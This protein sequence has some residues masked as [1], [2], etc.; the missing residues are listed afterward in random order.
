LEEVIIERH[1]KKLYE[2]GNTKLDS[3]AYVGSDWYINKSC[4]KANSLIGH[5]SLLM[6]YLEEKFDPIFLQKS[7]SLIDT[8]RDF[9]LNEKTYISQFCLSQV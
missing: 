3:K 6:E 5:I 2:N 1:L 7:K 9:I 8:H 4:S